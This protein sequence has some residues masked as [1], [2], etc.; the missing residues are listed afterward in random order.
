MIGTCGFFPYVRVISNKLGNVPDRYAWV[1][2]ARTPGAALP[3]TFYFKTSLAG[4]SC[5][6]PPWRPRPVRFGGALVLH[7]SPVMTTRLGS[8]VPAT[9]SR[10]S[11]DD[12]SPCAT[13][14]QRVLAAIRRSPRTSQAA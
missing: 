10:E 5:T 7:A 14:C 2:R 8:S 12:T 3:P 6:L 4:A 9:A 11:L 1:T 13:S